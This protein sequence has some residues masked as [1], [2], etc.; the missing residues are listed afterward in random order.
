MKICTFQMPIFYNSF[1]QCSWRQE[2]LSHRTYW[3]D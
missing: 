2:D 1:L 3:L